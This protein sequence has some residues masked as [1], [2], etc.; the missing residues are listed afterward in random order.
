MEIVCHLFVCLPIETINVAEI[1]SK[2]GICFL[3]VRRERES[4]YAL[5]ILEG[6]TIEIFSFLEQSL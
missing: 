1:H 2:E 4:L 6:M 5:R 3:M